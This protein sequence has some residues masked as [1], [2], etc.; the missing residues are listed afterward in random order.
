[1]KNLHAN[2]CMLFEVYLLRT[3]MRTMLENREVV[4]LFVYVAR[5]SKKCEGAG[6]STLLALSHNTK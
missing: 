1:M 3:N 4:T 6:V 2:G 5:F